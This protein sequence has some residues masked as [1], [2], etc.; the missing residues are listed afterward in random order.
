MLKRLV[1]TLAFAAFAL[2]VAGFVWIE[3]SIGQFQNNQ[4]TKHSEAKSQQPS[5]H[6]IAE[7]EARATE[8]IA[9]FT[10]V[11]A[12]A[13][14]A[15]F[16]LGLIQIWFVRRADKTSR[17]AADAATLTAKAAIGIEL[18]TFY[19]PP[20][21]LIFQKGDARCAINFINK[22]R[23][24]AAISET[25]MTFRSARALP[26]KPRYPVNSIEQH[27]IFLE[28][29]LQC[30]IARNHT[31]SGEE[32]DAALKGE[33]VLWVYGYFRYRDFLQDKHIERFCLGSR[34]AAPQGMQKVY[35]DGPKP[36]GARVV[37]WVSEGPPAYTKNG[38]DQENS[39]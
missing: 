25:C 31:F 22:G 38:Y 10:I 19:C 27:Q 13:N 36:H 29:D 34:P 24:F 16:G 4:P 35:A 1:D 14:A 15:L 3:S 33:T 32:W 21:N 7:R 2:W 28:K 30:T 11:L 37:E 17:I 18:P 9:N 12:F 8:T 23:T 5:E 20:P 26:P 39:D 6:I